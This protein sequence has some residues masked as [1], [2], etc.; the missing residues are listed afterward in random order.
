MANNDMCFC[1]FTRD[2]PG[3]NMN[4]YIFIQSQ[5][6]RVIMIVSTHVA[7]VKTRKK[8][9]LAISL[10]FNNN[11]NNNKSEKNILKTDEN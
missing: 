3:T 11:D 7:S 10:T 9:S 2:L 5:F 4:Y 8:K 1:H 6:R